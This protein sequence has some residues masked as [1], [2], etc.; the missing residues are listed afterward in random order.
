MNKPDI[1]NFSE[2]FDSSAPKLSKFDKNE[3]KDFF[4]EDIETEVSEST[5]EELE[6]IGKEIEKQVKPAEAFNP[7][8]D[9][10]QFVI[11]EEDPKELEEEESL[12]SIK[13]KNNFNKVEESVEDYFLVYKDKTENFSCDVLVE[14]AKISETQARLILETDEWTL[15]FEG[16]ID[17]YGKCNIPIKKLNLFDEG[18]TGRIRLEVIAENTVFTPWE[19]DFKVKMSKK[20]SIQLNE[21]NNRNR[22]TNSGSSVKVKF[23]K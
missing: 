22:N 20:V 4:L 11:D 7:P 14:G 3:F 19:D 5:I 17:R 23:R 15:L 8:V 16:D 13:N 18:V 21:S 9:I 1:I 10:K 2:F 6:K 12:P